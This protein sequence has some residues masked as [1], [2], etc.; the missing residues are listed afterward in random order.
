MNDEEIM[1]KFNETFSDEKIEQEKKKEI[2]PIPYKATSNN[3]MPQQVTSSI[4]SIPPLDSA[5]NMQARIMS[6]DDPSFTSY[7]SEQNYDSN[8]NYNYVPSYSSKK[9]KTFSLKMTPELLSVIV[10]ISLLLIAI[11]IIPTIYHYFTGL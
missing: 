8:V 4:S 5:N 6:V 1:K 11:M 7:N 3:G 10:I 2:A 9:K